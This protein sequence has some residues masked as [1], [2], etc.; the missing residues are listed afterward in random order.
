MLKDRLAREVRERWP[1]A[2]PG[3]R[4]PVR[5]GEAPGFVQ[6]L[7]RDGGDQR[8]VAV[9]RPVK[10]D[11]VQR[12]G[13]AAVERRAHLRRARSIVRAGRIDPR[14]KDLRI[15]QHNPC[16]QWQ[17]TRCRDESL[18]TGC[19]VRRVRVDYAKNLASL[20]VPAQQA[21]SIV[22]EVEDMG[23]CHG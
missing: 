22:A 1:R 23:G 9:G 16:G 15:G 13:C 17:H 12:V 5:F 11:L 6:R 8:G 18:Q 19:K 10:G 4:D 14:I 2:V 3:H 20:V 7:E 21:D